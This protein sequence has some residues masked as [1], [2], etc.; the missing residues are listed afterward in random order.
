M[1]NT[2]TGLSGKVARL[3]LFGLGLFVAGLTAGGPLSTA[4]AAD[5]SLAIAPFAKEGTVVHVAAEAST[6]WESDYSVRKMAHVSL[7]AVGTEAFLKVGQAFN[8]SH[9]ITFLNRVLSSSL[10]LGVGLGKE[11]YDARITGLPINTRDLGFDAI[12][13]LIG[14]ILQYQF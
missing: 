10:M 5:L 9:E 3:R 13:I 1:G 14:N 8:K 2:Q 4:R 7:S 6:G 12:G 11:V